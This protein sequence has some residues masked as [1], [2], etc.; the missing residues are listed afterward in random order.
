MPSSD[1]IHPA[2]PPTGH[3]HVVAHLRA[4][5]QLHHH[6]EL[7]VHGRPVGVRV[8]VAERRRSCG[9]GEPRPVG[10]AQ[11]QLGEPWEAAT[12]RGQHGEAQ[13]AGGVGRAPDE[14]L[15][16]RTSRWGRD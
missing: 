10:A 2:V 6:A 11:Q 13:V 15:L 5:R 4:H 9:A 3:P 8:A 1:R 12:V 7:T 16:C 14:V